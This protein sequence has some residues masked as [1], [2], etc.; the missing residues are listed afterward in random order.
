M[1][2]RVTKDEWSKVE[3]CDNRDWYEPDDRLPKHVRVLDP[4]GFADG[5]S[6]DRFHVFGWPPEFLHG[7]YA[8]FN[9]TGNWYMTC[10]KNIVVLYSY[11]V[12]KALLQGMDSMDDGDFLEHYES[13]SD[14]EASRYFLASTMAKNYKHGLECARLAGFDVKNLT[15]R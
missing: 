2:E 8:V 1:A 12:Q 13:M 5:S 10:R 9:Y 7:E 11:G 4:Y 14:E 15:N 6:T 3:M